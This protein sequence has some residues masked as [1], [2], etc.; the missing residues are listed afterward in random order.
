MSRAESEQS[1]FAPVMD[2]PQLY[3]K[4]TAETLLSTLSSLAILPPSFAV[5]HRDDSEP[6][7]VDEDDV[8]SDALSINEDGIP[9]Y[10]TRIVSNPLAWIA[11][12]STREEIWEAA[13]R[14]L[15]ERSGRTA[16][17]SV[18]RT[19]TIDIPDT[20]ARDD[21]LRELKINLYEPTLTGDN[22]G[23][24]TWIASYLLAKQLPTLVPRH[25]PRIT[26]RHNDDRSL[27]L[28]LGAGTGLVGLAASGLFS[29]LITL[30]DLDTIVPN[31]RYN[32]EK[33]KALT[34][35]TKSV[36]HASELDWSDA[37]NEEQQRKWD[38][39]DGMIG[40]RDNNDM[41]KYKY[42]I[43]LAADSLYAPEH[44][45]WLVKTMAAFSRKRPRSRIF[46]CLPLRAGSEYPGRFRE[47]LG[48]EGLEVIEEGRMI[49]YD[50]WQTEFGEAE[51]VQCWWSVWEWAFV[52]PPDEY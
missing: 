1:L 7:S 29:A 20:M 9:S 33:N 18:S 45:Q 39:S 16:M 30:T 40:Y 6:P 10:L 15:S 19:F 5:S 34:A 13:S 24:K 4:P 28:E 51:E 37:H 26:S 11:S 41:D 48:F 42:D 44:V 2:L 23:H 27:I 8:L 49:G 22:L 25:F 52:N 36:V 17:P 12:D 35:H 43:I 14:R 31:L 3:T 21:G 47:K 50:D 46:V 38:A 32:I